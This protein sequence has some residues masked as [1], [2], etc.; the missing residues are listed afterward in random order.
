MLLDG[1]LPQPA[2]RLLRDRAIPLGLGLTGDRPWR[3]EVARQISFCAGIPET[4]PA[5]TINIACG[6]GLKSLAL[7][8]DS[9]RLGHNRVV[10]VGGTESMSGLPYFLPRMRR[11]YRLGHAPVV[12]AMFQDGFHRPLA[13]MM[14]GATAE[15]LARDLEISRGEQDTYALQS[16]Q[17][18]GHAIAE[19][20]FDDELVPVEVVGRKEAVTV[21][22]DEH[23]RPDA[24]FEKMAK[25]PAVFAEKDGTVTPGN[26]SGITDGAAA[27]L[28]MSEDAAKEHGLEPLAYVGETR[29][30]GVEPE[31]HGHRPRPGRALE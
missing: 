28:L 9:I 27:L 2:Q 1:V 26:S 14:M 7:G 22:R 18:A 10:V 6:S 11:G 30:A 23:P 4:V 3:A 8:A 5:T 20:R 15:R 24:T 21:A 16:Q 25:L 19:G 31:G 17:R 29:Q 13:D 12:D